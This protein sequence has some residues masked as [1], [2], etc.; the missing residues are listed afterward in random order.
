MSLKQLMDFLKSL[1]QL[2][3]RYCMDHG[4]PL[5]RLWAGSVTNV[6]YHRRCKNSPKMKFFWHNFF[7]SL[8]SGRKCN[9]FTTLFN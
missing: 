2:I 9:Q 7:Q 6:E 1:V 3:C 4:S 5:N 8:R